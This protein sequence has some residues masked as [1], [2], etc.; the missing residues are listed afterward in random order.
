MCGIVGFVGASGAVE[1]VLEGL[2]RLEYRGYDSAGVAAL[3]GDG[4]KVVR[5]AGKVAALAD[6]VGGDCAPA[7]VAIGH[8]RWA[9]HGPPTERNAHPH[10]DC[11]GGI[12]VVHN[13][14]VE[15]Y[16]ALRDELA[17]GGHE[18][19]SDTDTEVIA[20]LIE[21]HLAETGDML[22]ALRAATAR[23]TGTY[24]CAVVSSGEPDA[25]WAAR[26]ESPLCIGVA[27]GATLLASDAVPVLP[28]TR[29]VIYLNDGDVARLAP[30]GVRVW[31]ESGAEVAPRV[32]VLDWDSERA[33]KG[34]Y[35]HFMLKEI[36]EQPWS[37]RETIRDRIDL[38]RGAVVLDEAGL[39]GDE[40]R[41]FD[42]IVIVACGTALHAG[43]VGRNMLERT[44][45]VGVQ[46]D[47]ASDFR[48]RDPIV[49]SRTLVVAI[50]QSGETADTL[51]AVREAKARH[52]RTLGIVN[53][54]GSSIARECDHLLPT[55]AGP[56]IGVASTKAFTS[57][58]AA[59]YLFAIHLGYV[60]GRFAEADLARR[61]DDV[62]GVAAGVQA[63]LSSRAE[64]VRRIALK[65]VDAKHALFLGRG[66]GYPLAL[67]G[68]LK[69]KEISYIHAEGY[70][71]AE[72]KHGPIALIDEEMPVVVLAL[73]GR[74]YAK[75]RSNIEEV[76]ARGG[77]VIALASEGDDEIRSYAEDVI[78][79]RAES[80]VM[81]SVLATLPLQLLAYHIA[82]ARGLNVDQPRNLAKSVTV[83]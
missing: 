78:P 1:A 34:G 50:S 71:A 17:S 48:Y 82:E 57:Q 15:N 77:L 46:V 80:G 22:E 19:R 23:L 74:R 66:T 75:I 39:A 44:A 12:A 67:E 59:L 40:L 83:E 60:R 8:T 7:A 65:Y 4:L 18:L 14:I 13:G 35:D 69:L 58:I 16:A 9:T 70:H 32:T 10:V 64:E 25:I 54:P 52:A 33:E 5:S 38:D 20:H 55:R 62:V 29:R 47:N 28:H 68:A 30:G 63:F 2:R 37:I 72:M 11:R 42:K 45:R 43:M 81:N 73:R 41:S 79:I 76:R 61:V 27:D 49:D 3:R 51:G 31:D 26:R 36:F 24:A 53:V 21:E 56:E 6:K